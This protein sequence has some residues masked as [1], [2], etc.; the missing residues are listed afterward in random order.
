[1]INIWK[2]LEINPRIIQK[3]NSVM[4]GMKW[5]EKE[6]K[7]LKLVVCLNNYNNTLLKNVIS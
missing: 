6:K 7:K 5:K 3:Y 1:M 4:I 2:Y